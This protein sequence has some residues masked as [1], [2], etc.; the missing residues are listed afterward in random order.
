MDYFSKMGKKAI[1][2]R[3]R[4]LSEQITE[5]A[6]HI[7]KL[8]DIDFNPKWFPVYYV[9]S[10]GEQKAVTTISKEIGHSHPSVSK[11]IR[12][13]QIKGLLVEKK[14][15][16][17]AR[18]NVVSLSKKGLEISH[19]IQFQYEDVNQVIEEILSQTNHNLWKALEEWEFVLQQKSLL[20]R[21]QEQQKIR[22]SREVSLVPYSAKHKKA[23]RDLNEEWISTYFAM[24]KED[25]KA[26]DNPKEYILDKGGSIIVALLNGEAVGICALIKM[27]DPE[28]DYELAKMAVAPKAQGRN[29]GF[30]LAQAIIEKAR[31]LG[32][33]KLYLE[34]NTLLKPA[35]NLYHKLGFQKVSGRESPYAR[36]NIQ[37]GLVL[38][39]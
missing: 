8:Y 12:E 25:Y 5:D 17:D 11:I 10:N 15:P 30:L 2:S 1:G 29:I 28:Y 33:K 35:I 39:K 26:L 13:M 27:K 16:K 31:S 36:S 22:A 9:L 24:E 32:A 19:K 14:D 23:F 3:L 7:Y 38:D 20:R 37:M 18:K 4:R 21:V 34:S 6:S